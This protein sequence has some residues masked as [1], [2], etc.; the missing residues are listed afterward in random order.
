MSE[1]RAGRDGLALFSTGEQAAVLGLPY[2]ADGGAAHRRLR[3]ALPDWAVS[4][5]GLIALLVILAGVFAVVLFASAGSH[6]FVARGHG[7]QLW[8]AGPL[9]WVLSRPIWPRPR[10]I[11]RYSELTALLTCAYAVAMLAGRRLPLKVIAAFV[12]IVSGIL[13]LGPPLPLNDVGDYLGYARLSGLHGLNPYTHVIYAERHDPA[14][15]LA[16]WRNLSSPYGPLF[17]IVTTPL[18]WLP[19]ATAYWVLK[20]VIVGLSLGFLWL[21]ARVAVRLHRDPRLPVLFVAANPIYLFYEVG[22]FHNDFLM[23]VPSMAAILLLATGRD[24]AAGAVLMLAV[25]VKFTTIV[26]LPFLLVAADSRDRRLR[27][28]TGAAL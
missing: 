1:D 19:L 24:R 26:L 20:V 17:T 25:A 12:V 28:L 14:Y 8:E 15:Q 11:R 27:V 16:T 13:L 10:V 23:L 18:A 4:A 2:G 3:V 21:V 22:G 6:A 5:T 9:H 7:F